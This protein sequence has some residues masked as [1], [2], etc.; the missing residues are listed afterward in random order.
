MTAAVALPALTVPAAVEAQRE[1]FKRVRMHAPG[2]DRIRRGRNPEAIA[3]ARSEYGM[4][5]L[6]WI[7]ASVAVAEA[8]DRRDPVWAGEAGR[9][10]DMFQN[11]GPGHARC[12]QAWRDYQKARLAGN[13]EAIAAARADWRITFV[14]W[15][16]EWS[17]QLAAE[18][19]WHVAE[20]LSRLDEAGRVDPQ[21]A[22]PSPPSSRAEEL[23]RIARERER[24]DSI[25]RDSA[26]YAGLQSWRPADS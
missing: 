2:Y 15:L 24:R 12:D 16:Q 10:R 25:R 19:E 26:R 18:D 5:V 17:A 8:E 20:L 14:S 11:A 9:T 3:K 6:E 23:V 1:A 7:E 22:F 13:V 21:D 4:A